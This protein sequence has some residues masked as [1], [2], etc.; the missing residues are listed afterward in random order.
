MAD[1]DSEAGGDMEGG[2]A[3]PVEQQDKG[4]DKPVMIKESVKLVPFQMQILEC[5]TTPLLGEMAHVMVTPL[6]A[7]KIQPVG[8]HPLPLGIH[9]L[10]T[11][12]RL[13]MDGKQ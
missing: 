10:P 13:K 8:K 4:I 12:T 6:K 3:A 1:L 11:Y 2:V 7:G 5:K 9:E